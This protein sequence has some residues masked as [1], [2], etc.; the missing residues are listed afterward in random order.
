M[1]F[2]TGSSI[3]IYR[4]VIHLYERVGKNAN[5]LHFAGGGGLVG[6]S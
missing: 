1:A 4:L 5:K 3:P 2:V 6:K